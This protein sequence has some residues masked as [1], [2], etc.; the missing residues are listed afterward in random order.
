MWSEPYIVV[1]SL[2]TPDDVRPK[3]STF[4]TPECALTV[5]LVPVGTNISIRPAP[6]QS[7]V[8]EHPDRAP[9]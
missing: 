8:L 5:T 2:P 9:A 3:M 7:L 4:P 1:V 6:E